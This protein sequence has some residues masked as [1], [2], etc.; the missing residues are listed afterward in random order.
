M[1]EVGSI[2]ITV[3][4]GV[5]V[6]VG[7]PVGGGGRVDVW[8]GDGSKMAV[9]VCAAAAVLAM[10]VSIG[11]GAEFGDDGAVRTGSSHASRNS[12]VENKRM[13]F[14]TACL[15]MSL[16]PKSYLTLMLNLTE[17]NSCFPTRR[18]HL[19]EYTFASFGAAIEI[20]IVTLPSGLIVAGIS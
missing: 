6:S 12:T 3:A 9:C 18:D 1:V 15:S 17:Q 11:R 13:W 4:V 2:K 14:L 19:V 7:V 16:N 5:K 8:V 20:V 10:T